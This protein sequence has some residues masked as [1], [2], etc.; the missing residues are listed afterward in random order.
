MVSSSFLASLQGYHLGSI[1]GTAGASVETPGSLS[2][3]SRGVGL[4]EDICSPA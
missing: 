2:S 1:L 3:F 4:T